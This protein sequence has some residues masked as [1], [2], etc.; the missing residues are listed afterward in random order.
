MVA[1][2]AALQAEVLFEVAAHALAEELFPAVAVFGKCGIGVLFLERDDVWVGLLVAVVDAGGG[3]VEEAL[4]ALFAGRHEH[5]R[6]GQ[7]AQH[8]EGFVVFDEAHAAHVG[9]KLEDDVSACGSLEAAVLVLQVEGEVFYAVRYLIPL[10]EGLDIDR[11]DD[12]DAVVE[13]ALDQMAAD[14]A[15]GAADYG[16]FSLEL[17]SKGG[18]L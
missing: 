5:V 6:V 7:H 18:L 16:F 12:F 9:G 3:G 10:V 4:D 15:A 1:G 14:K 11:A 2:D 13:Q 8:A 17:H